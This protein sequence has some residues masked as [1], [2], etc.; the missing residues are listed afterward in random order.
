MTANTTEAPRLDKYLWAVRLFKTRTLATEAIRGGHVT[1]NGAPPKPAHEVKI[2]ETYQVQ[3]GEIT[4]TIKVIAL[5]EK[6][7]GA[8]LVANF[9][10]DLT[11]A[12][13]Y[14]KQM[15][16]REAAPLKRPAGAGRPTKRDRRAI[17]KLL[18]EQ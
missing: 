14:L 18:G 8:K 12:S 5:L 11:P 17:E 1:L 3:Q 16:A 6:R 9:A 13:E 2:G 7:V 10:E 4:R 15:Q